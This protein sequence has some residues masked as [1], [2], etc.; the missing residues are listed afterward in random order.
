MSK[1]LDVDPAESSW[2]P[3]PTLVSLP[4]EPLRGGAAD[5][6]ES[7]A[8]AYPLH[9][10]SSREAALRGEHET[11]PPFTQGCSPL[12]IGVGVFREAYNEQDRIRSVGV[13][14]GESRRAWLDSSAGWQGL[15]G[16]GD[17]K[18]LRRSRGAVLS[19]GA[20]QGAPH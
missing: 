14:R 19:Q 17:Q 13:F 10:S 8:V 20:G 11:L 12:F 4:R 15:C 5:W 9:V 7:R 3:L 2:G 18:V 16:A 6:V 1:A